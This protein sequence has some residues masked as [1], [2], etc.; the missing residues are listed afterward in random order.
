MIIL[1]I[2]VKCFRGLNHILF[3]RPSC[4][5]QWI[6]NIRFIVLLGCFTDQIQN[7]SVSHMVNVPI[8]GPEAPYLSGQ[9]VN[10]S[11]DGESVQNYLMKMRDV[12]AGH[13]MFGSDFLASSPPPREVITKR[14]LI[15]NQHSGAQLDRY[16]LDSYEFVCA[17]KLCVG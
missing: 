8:G 15:H 10:I 9:D 17:L 1:I 11:P 6:F 16:I 14:D 12:N 3:S 5:G 4:F 7:L 13:S 2:I